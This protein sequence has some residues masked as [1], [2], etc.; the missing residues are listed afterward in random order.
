[1]SLC[2]LRVCK[3]TRPILILQKYGY[4][5]AAGLNN[6]PS[7]SD[8]NSSMAEGWIPGD[9]TEAGAVGDWKERGKDG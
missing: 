2:L 7:V 3:E 4:A 5:A 9:G 1:M 8:L 6:G